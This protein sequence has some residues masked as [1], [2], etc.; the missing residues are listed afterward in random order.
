MYKSERIDLSNIKTLLNYL[1]YI[2]DLPYPSF[3]NDAKK[4]FSGL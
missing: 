1:K 3:E 2:K 4:V